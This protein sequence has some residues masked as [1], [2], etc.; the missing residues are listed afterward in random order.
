M[1]TS[2]ELVLTS[3]SLTQL[4]SC[5]GPRNAAYRPY[6]SDPSNQ[7]APDR[8]ACDPLAFL[9]RTACAPAALRQQPVERVLPPF[10]WL[11]DEPPFLHRRLL[12]LPQLRVEGVAQRVAEQA[13][14]EHGERDRDAGEDRDPRRGRGVFLGA[15]LQHQAPGG[16]GLL[17]AE[18]EVGEQSLGQ[19][20][21]AD[22]GGDK[23]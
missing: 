19:D 6:F 15:A 8:R 14:A 17:H 1:R 10:L 20:C 21:L 12:P 5:A 16:D 13:E 2:R 7:F 23:A 4:R 3:G 22:E 11:D 18:P 9:T